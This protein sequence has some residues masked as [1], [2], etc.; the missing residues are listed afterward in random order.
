M[1]ERETFE[2]HRPPEDSKPWE[3]HR[4][5]LRRRAIQEGFDAL[6]ENQ[7]IELLLCYAVPRMDVSDIAKSLID[8]F[9]VVTRVLDASRE[10]LLSVPGMTG[11]MADWL[12]MTG[13]LLRAYE[14]VDP[15]SPYRIG[16]F[17]DVAR[18]LAPLWPKVPAPQC[19][20]LYTDFEGRLL[21]QS[22]I[23]PSL[24]WAD[25]QYAIE[26]V[27]EAL[28][29]QAKN[30]FLVMFAGAEP[31]ELA[32]WELDYLVALSRTLRAIDV[33]LLDCVLT[34]DAGMRSMSQEGRMD[35]IIRESERLE[36]H[37]NYRGSPAEDEL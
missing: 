12:Q 28:S 7:L 18:L 1:N 5:R 20:M 2:G 3:G 14:R 6:R 24:N 4:E 10:A 30:A 21:M 15:L 27:Q 36:L 17:R 31:L 32:Q 8:R 22:V 35:Q 11:G 34:G 9:G 33:E 19:W 23:C 25:P 26:I 37:E 16:C 29:I 13:E